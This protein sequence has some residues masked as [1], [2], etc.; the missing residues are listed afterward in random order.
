MGQGRLIEIVTRNQPV[1]T[2]RRL[3][4]GKVLWRTGLPRGDFPSDPVYIDG[5]VYVD[6]TDGVATFVEALAARTGHRLWLRK[7]SDGEATDMSVSPASVNRVLVAMNSRVVALSAAT[8][9]LRWSKRG[10][11]ENPSYGHGRFYVENLN[12]YGHAYRATNGHS[13]MT[14]YTAQDSPLAVSGRNLIASMY[15]DDEIVDFPATSCHHRNCQPRWTH[16][17]SI[18]TSFVAVAHGRVAA[19]TGGPPDH[20][21][22]FRE[23]DGHLDARVRIPGGASSPT[24]AGNVV[25]FTNYLTGDIDAYGLRHPRHRVWRHRVSKRRADPAGTLVAIDRNRIAAIVN[26]ELVVYRLR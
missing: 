21:L 19:M 12:G 17:T 22:V 26:D 14:F 1:V 18:P 2:A 15:P 25:F 24:I 10:Y 20:L 16:G 3:G 9:H 11:G 7:F 5:R 8:G 4:S 6:Y 23:R 13:L